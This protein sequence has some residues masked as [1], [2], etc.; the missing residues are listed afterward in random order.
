MS[1]AKEIADELLK[2]V[3]K[4]I[5]PEDFHDGKPSNSMYLTECSELGILL[6]FRVVEVLLVLS[7]ITMPLSTIPHTI[8]K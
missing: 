4:E 1:I 7:L 8:T 2:A 3:P 6:R 5:D